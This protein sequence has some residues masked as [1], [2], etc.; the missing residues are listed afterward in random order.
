MVNTRQVK[1]QIA[2]LRWLAQFSGL[3][4]PEESARRIVSHILETDSLKTAGKFY[5]LEK[6]HKPKRQIVNGLSAYKEL[7][8]YSERVTGISIDELIES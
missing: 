3:M 7:I 1:E 4:E 2:I 6:E 5:K 8:E